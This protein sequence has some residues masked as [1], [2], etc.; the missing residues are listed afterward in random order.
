ME[1]PAERTDEYRRE[2][3]E[4]SVLYPLIALW[5]TALGR[6]EVLKDIAEFK[7]E[8]L[9]HCTFQ[10]WLPDS[11]SEDHVYLGDDTHGAALIDIP[12]IV[13]TLDTLELVTAE[14]VTNSHFNNLSAITNGH[15]PV[16]LTACRHYRLPIPPHI[17]R[18]LFPTMLK[19]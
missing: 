16:L 2:M 19:K 6:E 17:W 4:G 15:W 13:G 18:D 11:D 5:A 7:A 9:A 10:F 12:V 3:T 8:H 1:H 14:C